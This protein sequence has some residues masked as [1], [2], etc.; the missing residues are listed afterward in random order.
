M[1]QGLLPLRACTFSSNNIQTEI[2]HTISLPHTIWTNPGCAEHMSTY[3]SQASQVT[4]QAQL[5]R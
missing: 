3:T 2:T 1:S 4:N 5:A